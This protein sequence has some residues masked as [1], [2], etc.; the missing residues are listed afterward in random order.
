MLVVSHLHKN[1]KR[2]RMTKKV[3]FSTILIAASFVMIQSCAKEN[4]TATTSV[5]NKIKDPVKYYSS[6][7]L[8][9]TSFYK[10]MTTMSK[11]NLKMAKIFKAKNYSDVQARY[12][13]SDSNNVYVS[14]A[15][16]VTTLYFLEKDHP[17]FAELSLNDQAAILNNVGDSLTSVAFRTTNPQNPLIQYENATIPSL[18]DVDS[19]AVQQRFSFDHISSGEFWTCTI[20]VGVAALSNYGSVLKDL[21]WLIQNG[22]NSWGAVFDLAYDLIKNACPWWKVAA[23]AIGYATCLWNAGNS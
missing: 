6:L 18:I 16:N 22:A 19:I 13:P 12:T 23:M 3:L 2:Q 4:T 20:G 21:K 7:F 9:D 11:N 10:F 5:K 15:E 14:A 1:L 17:D 8:T